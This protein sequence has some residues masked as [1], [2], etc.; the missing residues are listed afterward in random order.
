MRILFVLA[1]LFT[2]A[3]CESMDFTSVTVSSGYS[4]Y[5]PV[6]HISYTLGYYSGNYYNGYRVYGSHGHRYYHAPRNYRYHRHF[7]R[8]VVVH[9]HVHTTYCEH[10]Y[11]PRTH[12][13]PPAVVRPPPRHTPPRHTP[14]RHT[15]PRRTPP[16]A[17]PPQVRNDRQP[18]RER[19][20][21]ND[22]REDRQDRNDRRRDRERKRK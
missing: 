17:V 16:R 6:N 3:G 22:R 15:P 4:H 9:Q 21:R 10:N 2:L 18:N 5:Y 1:A 8:P 14:P 11:R 13:T 20:H 19:N 7:A 12:Y